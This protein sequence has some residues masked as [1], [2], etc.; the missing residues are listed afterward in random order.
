MIVP[1]AMMKTYVVVKSTDVTSAV[2]GET[3]EI[4]K[5]ES[6]TT[7]GGTKIDVTDLTYTAGACGAATG[8][9]TCSAV[10]SS[11]VAS[12]YG[13]LVVTDSSAGTGRHIIVGGWKVNKLAKALDLEAELTA[14]GDKVVDVTADGDVVVAGYTASD[15]GNAAKELIAALDA[16]LA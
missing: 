14:A 16:G 4:A 3:L 5:G 2:T 11:S 7:T 8:D 15:T 12:G 10:T 6:K 13:N 1:N 9:I